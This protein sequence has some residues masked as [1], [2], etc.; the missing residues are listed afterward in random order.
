MY[1]NNDN[2]SQQPESQ[3]SSSHVYQEYYYSAGAPNG[4]YG[5]TID[6]TPARKAKKTGGFGKKAVSVACLGL[7]FGVSAGAAFSIPASFA[8][9]DLRAAKLEVQQMQSSL[10]TSEIGRAHV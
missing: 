7:V 5:Q 6:A 1:E 8:A 9:K 3:G 2:Y 4:N 10:N